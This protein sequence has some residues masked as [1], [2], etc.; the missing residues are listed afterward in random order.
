MAKLSCACC[1]K[2]TSDLRYGVCF[3]C[4]EA[5]SII[6]NGLDMYD[7]SVQDKMQKA[8]PAMNKVRFLI[9]KGWKKVN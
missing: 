4:T 2:I 8:S 3:D 9:E 7:N 6:F 5:E 1:K